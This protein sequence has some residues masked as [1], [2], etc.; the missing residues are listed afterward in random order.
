MLKFDVEVET[1]KHMK[2]HHGNH[3]STENQQEIP[4]Q[5]ENNNNNGNEGEEVGSGDSACTAMRGTCTTSCSGGTFH[6]DLC[7]GAANVR[8]CVKAAAP[9]APGCTAIH[10]SCTTSCSGGTFH[11]GLCPGASNI[12][13]CVKNAA[14]A[15]A[16]A[17][18]KYSSAA[19]SN[20]GGSCTS[21][22]SGGHTVGGL[23]PGPA[24]ITCCYHGAVKGNG[25]CTINTASL[26]LVKSFEGFVGHVYYDS[27]GVRT[28][29]YGCTSACDSMT[30][31]SEPEA[32][33][34][35]SEML[36][37]DYGACVRSKVTHPLTENQYGALTSFV[38]NLGCGTLEGNLLSYINSGDFSA[39][40]SD[41]LQY[42]HAGNQVLAGLQR[43]RE[44]EVALMKE[45]S[46]MC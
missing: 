42:D 26:D 6:S 35:L 16:P 14:P 31:I 12:R 18:T 5:Q 2:H 4:V 21:S 23:C 45:S 39:A 13:C 38:Y 32:A 27:V 20:L 8:C 37:N 30:S 1:G 29:G 25:A 33:T 44:A 36:Q 24:D 46:P 3:H 15:P 28:I 43:R 41:M 19:C 11:S 34:M 17:P 9:S 7:P 22:C 10:G 40:E